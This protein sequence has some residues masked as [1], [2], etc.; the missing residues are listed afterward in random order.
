MSEYVCGSCY[1]LVDV[2]RGFGH[3][4]G[5]PRAERSVFIIVETANGPSGGAHVYARETEFRR[6][7]RG[8]RFCFVFNEESHPANPTAPG[9]NTYTAASDAYPLPEKL[10]FDNDIKLNFPSTFAVEVE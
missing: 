8:D 9:I 2:S 3:E 5:C 7:R 1:K 10:I 4:D 6:I